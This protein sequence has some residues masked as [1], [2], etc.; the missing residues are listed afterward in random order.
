MK[1]LRSEQNSVSKTKGKAVPWLIKIGG[2]FL[3]MGGVVSFVL[4][5]VIFGVK[6]IF[7]KNLSERFIRNFRL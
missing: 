2:C 7:E 4:S 5:G 1:R 6:S 3:A